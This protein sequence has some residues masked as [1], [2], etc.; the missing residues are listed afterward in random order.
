[1]LHCDRVFR[2]QFERRVPLGTLRVV[3]LYA[4][5]ID[6]VLP[7]NRFFEEGGAVQSSFSLLR[8]Y[9]CVGLVVLTRFKPE[10]L[11]GWFDRQIRGGNGHSMRIPSCQVALGAHARGLRGPRDVFRGARSACCK[12]LHNR[13]CAYT[14]WHFRLRSTRGPPFP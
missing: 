7:R 13:Q 3:V 1:M 9:E 4:T 6:A 2:F 11:V 10:A 8:C 5:E 14:E 12:Q